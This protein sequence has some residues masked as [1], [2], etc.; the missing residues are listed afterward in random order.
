MG[1]HG[2]RTEQVG[3][4]PG[5]VNFCYLLSPRSWLQPAEVIGAESW[6]GSCCAEPI[7]GG[8]L[9]FGQQGKGF[10]ASP[11]PPPT[12]D[13]WG[14]RYLN[15]RTHSPT[16]AAQGLPVPRPAQGPSLHRVTPGGIG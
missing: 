9:L 10:S 2:W 6:K 8:L 14:L 11:P 4:G 3:G 16:A 12:P 13:C 1:L 15:G 5:V 7:L